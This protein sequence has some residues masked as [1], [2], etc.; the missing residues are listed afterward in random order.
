MFKSKAFNASAIFNYKFNKLALTFGAAVAI[1]SAGAVA[2]PLN[3]VQNGSFETTNN[4]N[5]SQTGSEVTNSNLPGWQLSSCISSCSGPNNLFSFILQSNYATNGFNDAEYGHQSYF[6]S[7]PGASPDGGNLYAAD[8]GYQIGTLSQTISGL[9]VGQT[10]QLSFYQAS[11]QQS[12]YPGNFTASWDVGFG[13][14]TENSA[15][16]VNPSLGDTPWT[17]QTMD[18]TASS[19]SQALSFMATA[20]NSY[21]PFL[22]LDGVSLTAVP[23]PAS[24]ALVGVGV[25]GLLV[26]RRKRKVARMLDIRV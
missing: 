11:V 17:L 12:G 1:F 6:A 10:Y 2:S 23:E 3:L 19:V 13:N 14:Q 7:A 26:L 16:M 9:N 18:F 25:L 4:F 5:P 8:G 22:L 20:T 15:T 24:F 21:P